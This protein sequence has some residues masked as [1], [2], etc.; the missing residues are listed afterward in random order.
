MAKFVKRGKRLVPRSG[1]EKY[2]ANTI[3]VYD[4]DQLLVF[5]VE[6]AQA[7]LI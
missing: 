6:D 1:N 4:G 3:A 5:D 7:P 2:T